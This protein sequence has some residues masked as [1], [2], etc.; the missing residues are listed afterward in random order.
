MAL[1]RRPHR[2][3]F[4]FLR[5][6]VPTQGNEARSVLNY[7][8]CFWGP[9][10][11]PSEEEINRVTFSEVLSCLYQIPFGHASSDLTLTFE[12]CEDALRAFRRNVPGAQHSAGMKKAPFTAP[13]PHTGHTQRYSALAPQQEEQRQGPCGWFGSHNSLRYSILPQARARL[14]P[15][16]NCKVT[17]L[18]IYLNIQTIRG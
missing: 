11:I 4:P 9:V 8:A 3:W 16:I 7:S 6:N 15:R 13:T 14:S 12:L 17:N 1:A 18:I 10:F 2:G 5:L